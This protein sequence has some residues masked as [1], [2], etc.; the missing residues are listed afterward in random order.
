V[1]EGT[2][3]EENDRS[4]EGR[5]KLQEGGETRKMTGGRRDE[6]NDRREEGRGK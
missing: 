2:R 3:D 1:T 5:E 6:E 4:E